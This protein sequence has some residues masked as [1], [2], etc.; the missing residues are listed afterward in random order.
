MQNASGSLFP[1][2]VYYWLPEFIIIFWTYRIFM[3]ISYLV[4]KEFDDS[5]LMS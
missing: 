1:W 5:D 3:M 4:F 2:V